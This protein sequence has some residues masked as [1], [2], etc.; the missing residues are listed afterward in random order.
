MNLAFKSSGS[1]DSLRV[2]MLIVTHV[3]HWQQAESRMF[4][5]M[6]HNCAFPAR[7]CAGRVALTMVQYSVHDCTHFVH[8]YCRCCAQESSP[9]WFW[10]D[11]HSLHKPYLGTVHHASKLLMVAFTP[12]HV[13]HRKF[14]STGSTHA[15]PVQCKFMHACGRPVRNR[16]ALPYTY[17]HLVAA[18]S[19]FPV[20]ASMSRQS[21]RAANRPSSEKYVST[22]TRSPLQ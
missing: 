22:V 3:L 14:P 2:A 13:K 18:P 15:Q 9:R 1:L 11:A 21:R 12:L 10:Y 17:T 6:T 4:V 19:T 8:E 7:R 5:R 20:A 16:G